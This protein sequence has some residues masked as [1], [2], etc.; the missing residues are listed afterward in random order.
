MFL[1]ISAFMR[2]MV[3]YVFDFTLFIE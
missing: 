3:N 2:E 1:A